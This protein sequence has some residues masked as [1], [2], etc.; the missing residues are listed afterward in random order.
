MSYCEDDVPNFKS[1]ER[2]VHFLRQNYDDD[3]VKATGRIEMDLVTLLI[4]TKKR[5]GQESSSFLF[6]P[7]KV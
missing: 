5:L 3:V 7:G 4:K 2:Y 6:L 1:R